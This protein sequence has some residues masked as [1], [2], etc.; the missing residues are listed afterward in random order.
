[1]RCGDREAMPFEDLERR[2][3]VRVV[4]IGVKEADSHSSGACVPQSPGEVIDGVAIEG[5]QD[6]PVRGHAFGHSQ[7]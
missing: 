2:L 3:L 4:A 5:H 6:R 1:M 7:T